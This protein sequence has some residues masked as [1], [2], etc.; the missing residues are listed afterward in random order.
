MYGIVSLIPSAGIRSRLGVV[1]TVGGVRKVNVDGSILTCTWAD[2]IVVDDGDPVNVEFRSSG[3]GGSKAHVTSRTASQ[4]RPR[5]GIVVQV[6]AGSETI[7]IR[8]GGVNYD[9]EPVEGPYAANDPVH[10]DWGAGRPRVIGKVS[11]STAPAV[12]VVTTPA[13][14]PPEIPQTG[15]Q[16]RPALWSGSFSG[17]GWDEG[18]VLQG[19]FSGAWFYGDQYINLGDRTIT[20]VQF[21][22]GDR[23]V[24]GEH[25]EPVVFRFYAHTS[26]W[27]P[28]GDVNRVLGP[29]EWSAEP[30]QGPAWILLPEEFGAVIAGGGGISIEGG[31]YAG[32]QG[33][34]THSPESG[35]LILDWT[36]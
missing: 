1:V 15:Y 31:E 9:A 11:L 4:P 34:T 23:L 14:A 10:L 32:M 5:T 36:F 30:G 8:A 3:S 19:D 26:P 18:G 33:V 6:P 35:A 24:V 20:K 22:T 25:A 16:S 12:P 7:K 13:P 2:P 29:F 28:D 17:G 21:R 27:R